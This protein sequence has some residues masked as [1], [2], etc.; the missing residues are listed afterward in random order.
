M[1]KTYGDSGRLHPPAQQAR[2]AAFARHA[3]FNQAGAAPKLAG[4]YTRRLRPRDLRRA[5]VHGNRRSIH[6][7]TGGRTWQQD[8]SFT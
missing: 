7:S 5:D 8:T 2:Q 1:G 6:L 4:M 3:V